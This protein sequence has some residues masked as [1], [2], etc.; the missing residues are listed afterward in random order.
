LEK[1]RNPLF[2]ELLANACFKGGEGTAKDKLKKLKSTDICSAVC[3]AKN[4]NCNLSELC[5]DSFAMED[6][7]IRENICAC[8]FPRDSSIYTKFKDSLEERYV[9]PATFISGDPHCF[10][11]H[12]KTSSYANKIDQLNC[13]QVSV[14]SCLTN[15]QVDNTGA[16]IRGS[17]IT[18]KSEQNCGEIKAVDPSKPSPKPQPT[19]KPNPSDPN[20]KPNP[21]TPS[22]DSLGDMWLW[23]LGG[24]SVAVIA[25]FALVVLK[26]QQGPTE[27]AVGPQPTDASQP[28]SPAEPANAT[29]TS[30]TSA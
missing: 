25:V 20:P 12:C 2:L 22:G 28:Q 24:A 30:T 19:P 11:P 21:E 27:S 8:H 4:E 7:E 3:R 6:R 14:V 15:V 18:V 17:P 26:K 23:I 5:K 29:A 16:I 9:I 10:Y 13:P 1:H